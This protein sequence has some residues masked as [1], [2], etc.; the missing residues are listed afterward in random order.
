MTFD[1]FH[2]ASDEKLL[3]LE[4]LGRIFHCVGWICGFAFVFSQTRVVP[5]T[6][7]PC[8]WLVWKIW[9]I[10]QNLKCRQMSKKI[11]KFNFPSVYSVSMGGIDF[12]SL[13]LNKQMEN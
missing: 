12:L 13:K 10:F 8:A 5:G 11:N 9:Q 4:S 6:C 3:V 1:A 2:V 7:L